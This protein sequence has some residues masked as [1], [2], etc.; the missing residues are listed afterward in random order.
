M[1]ASDNFSTFT[2][3]Q[4]QAI[5]LI[6]DFLSDELRQFFTLKG[7]AGTG[8]SYITCAIALSLHHK[9]VA[10]T[11]P[12]NNAVD[13]IRQKIKDIDPLAERHI[14]FLTLHKY[15]GLKME[16]LEDTQHLVYC[17]KMQDTKYDVVFVDECSMV[18]EK[19]FNIIRFRGK[20]SKW[21]F[22]GDPAQLE[23]V[24]EESSPCFSHVDSQYELTEVVRSDTSNPVSAL[25]NN[26]RRLVDGS[27]ATLAEIA[28]SFKSSY[29]NHQKFGVWCYGH[30]DRKVWYDQ[31]L[32]AFSS[33][34][35]SDSCN[36][37]RVITWRNSTER[38]INS[39]V[40][41]KLLDTDLHYVLGETIFTKD[42][43]MREGS[44]VISTASSLLIT[45]VK[46]KEIVPKFEYEG[47]RSV[48]LPGY[49]LDVEVNGGDRVMIEVIHPQYLVK[50]SEYKKEVATE[51]KK[52]T[53][54]ARQYSMWK[55]YWDIFG[56]I[57]EVSY[58]YALTVRRSQGMT[59]NN[60]FPCYADLMSAPEGIS[61]YRNL[62]VALSR[63]RERVIMLM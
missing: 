7:Y 3:Q 8:K 52:R 10:V 27:N 22:I 19:L 13:V 49:R 56:A 57:P 55:D 28:P 21:I 35:A 29:P 32:R 18:G 47:F 20:T 59:I 34:K 37:A 24:G 4:Q 44:V 1:L 48:S 33:P 31:L 62:Y 12:S 45:S 42:V 38:M 9:K 6:H 50:W 30:S 16:T 46:E 25:V 58:K 26:V 40:R 14:S 43:V 39:Y 17:D 11:A 61:K 51:I 54:S 63:A 2:E 41:N 53:K 5:A 36:F 23:P 15:L 60:V